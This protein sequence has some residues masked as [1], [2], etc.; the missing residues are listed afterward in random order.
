MESLLGII[1]LGRL[2]KYS[3][4]E[5]IQWARKDMENLHQFLQS[6]FI[7]NYTIYISI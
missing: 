1:T 6:G 5:E 3:L 2:E 7:Y 4:M